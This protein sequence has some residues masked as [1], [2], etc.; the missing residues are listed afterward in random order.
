M[1]TSVLKS[2]VKELKRSMFTM[3]LTKS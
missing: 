1:L 2:F 3:D